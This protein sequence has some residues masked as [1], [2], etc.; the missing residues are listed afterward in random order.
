MDLGYD[1]NL[2]VWME[3]TIFLLGKKKKPFWN[4][5]WYYYLSIVVVPNSAAVKQTQNHH[6]YF[7]TQTYQ[8]PYYSLKTLLVELHA[9]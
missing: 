1:V 3:L 4:E 7:A 5:Y 2:C 9:C 6:L 8:I